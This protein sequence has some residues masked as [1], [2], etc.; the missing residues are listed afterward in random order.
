MLNDFYCINSGLTE[1][2]NTPLHLEKV[3]CR[4]L[5]TNSGDSCQSSNTVFHFLNK[6]ISGKIYPRKCQPHIFRGVHCFSGHLCTDCLPSP[7]FSCPPQPSTLSLKARH[8]TAFWWPLYSL[9]ISPVSTHH[10]RAR[11]SEEAVRGEQES[12]P[13]THFEVYLH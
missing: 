5:G 10:R 6:N 9:L 13:D 2:L 4:H 7:L 12:E 11:L 1:M 3:H 8:T